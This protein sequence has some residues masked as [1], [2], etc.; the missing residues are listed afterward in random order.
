LDNDQVVRYVGKKGRAESPRARRAFED[1]LRMAP[2]RTQA[3]SLR[4]L[5][6]AYQQDPLAPTK[7]WTTLTN[8]SAEYEWVQRAA[9]FDREQAARL[10]AEYEDRRRAIMETGLALAHERVGK[11]V[12]IFDRLYADFADENKVWLRDKKGIGS[13]EN[14]E[15]VEVIRFNAGLISELRAALDDIASET[16]G[17]PRKTELTGKG[18]GPIRASA[19]PFDTSKLSDE[20]LAMLEDILESASGDDEPAEPGGSAG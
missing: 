8:W 7:S 19:V 6:A 14:F 18:G 11:L 15:V 10:A 17:R 9:Q 3:R 4:N 5:L 20:K 2:G 1:Y 12:E 16:G 13:F